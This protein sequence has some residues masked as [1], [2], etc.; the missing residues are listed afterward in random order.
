MISNIKIGN[1]N[2]GS[3]FQPLIVAEM[4]GNHNQSLDKALK[5][6]KEVAK[7]GANALKIQTYTADTLTIDIKDGDFFLGDKNSL[8]HGTSMYDLYTKAHTPW[9]WHSEIMKRA[10]EKG[11][12]CFST[13]FDDSA[14]DFLESLDEVPG[15]LTSISDKV[16]YDRNNIHSILSLVM[17]IWLILTS[18]MRR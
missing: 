4:S 11:I 13:P 12:E 14:V 1:L 8:W 7:T 3:N 6:V 17:S 5:I 2:L 9:E 10:R 15:V 16:V 18:L